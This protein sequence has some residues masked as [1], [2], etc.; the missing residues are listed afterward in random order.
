[1]PLVRVG[2]A[3]AAGAA[4]HGADLSTVPVAVKP[5]LAIA[6]ASSVRRARRACTV[7]LSWPVTRI[8]LRVAAW[9]LAPASR[10]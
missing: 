3:G 9:R 4:A 6:A 8:S 2:M 10:R 7:L 1:M 5:M